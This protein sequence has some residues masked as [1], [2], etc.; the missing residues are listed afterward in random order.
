MF[1]AHSASNVCCN[2]DSVP[3]LNVFRLISR[4]FNTH[5]RRSENRVQSSSVSVYGAPGRVPNSEVLVAD[6]PSRAD[7]TVKRFFSHFSVSSQ[8]DCVLSAFSWAIMRAKDVARCGEGR[9]EEVGL[10][11]QEWGAQNECKKLRA[12]QCM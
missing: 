5:A 8:N 12:L 11:A 3:I 10:R 2:S 1:A 4:A 6:Q 9:C 7:I